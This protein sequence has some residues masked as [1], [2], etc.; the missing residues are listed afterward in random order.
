MSRDELVSIDH[1]L[2]SFIY[3]VSLYITQSST[4]DSERPHEN[5]WNAAGLYILSLLYMNEIIPTTINNRY[6]FACSLSFFSLSLVQ[7]VNYALP[8][9]SVLAPHFKKLNMNFLMYV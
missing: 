9:K 2:A 1:L 4:F 5:T 3:G 6:N 7:C 8:S